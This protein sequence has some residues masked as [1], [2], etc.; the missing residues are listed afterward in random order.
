M[1]IF[2]FG[3]SGYLGS[4]L[5]HCLKHRHEVVALVRSS[6]SLKRLI[7]EEVTIIKGIE[8]PKNLQKAFR[9]EMPH[10]VINT[11]ALYGRNGEGFHEL[12]EANVSFPSRLYEL[13]SVHHVPY[14]LNTGT[15]LPDNVSAYALTKN[16][17]TNGIN[18]FFTFRGYRK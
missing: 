9:N 17:F 10:L 13:C 5:V 3:A 6:S 1:K 11:A 4:H 18:C 2:I 16:C 12:V 14:F 7:S 8:N 15:S